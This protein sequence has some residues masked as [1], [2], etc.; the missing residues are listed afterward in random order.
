MKYE[1]KNMRNVVIFS[2]ENRNEAI[3]FYI[4]KC[5]K[6]RENNQKPVISINTEITSKDYE[7]E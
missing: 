3:S 4:K 5:R 7:I 2:S 6:I 1:V